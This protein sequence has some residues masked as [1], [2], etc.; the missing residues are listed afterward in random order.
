M[1]E[2][3]LSDKDVLKIAGGNPGVKKMSVRNPN[4]LNLSRN[5]ISTKRTKQSTAVGNTSTQRSEIDQPKPVKKDLLN[6]YRVCL[7]T[8]E[9]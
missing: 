6:L 8:L 9:R 2:R 7:S 5:N 3:L 1:A 4:K